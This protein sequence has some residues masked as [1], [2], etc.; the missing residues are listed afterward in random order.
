MGARIVEAPVM[1]VKA[2]DVKGTEV[3][4][5][6]VKVCRVPGSLVGSGSQVSVYPTVSDTQVAGL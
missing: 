3:K 4:V 5:V 2:T 6:E 1:G